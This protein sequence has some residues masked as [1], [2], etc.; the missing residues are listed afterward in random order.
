M[1]M[2]SPETGRLGFCRQNLVV[3]GLIGFG[4]GMRLF[5]YVLNSLGMISLTD[6]ATYAWNV[7]PIPAICLLGGAYLTQRG[8]G[9]GLGLIAYVLSDVMVG[10]ISGQ[11][12]MA[13]YKT[14]PFVYVGLLLHGLM[15]ATISSKAGAWR[16]GATAMA[17]EIVF[18][19]FTNFGEWAIGDMNYTKDLTG[20][21]ICYSAALPFLSRALIGTLFYT[22]VL[23]G[24]YHWVQ[25]HARD[26]L[27]HHNGKLELVR[28][29]KP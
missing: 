22:T 9:F 10:W 28:V 23:F 2:N 14:L 8:L 1:G 16:I 3:L 21:G 19:L 27:G 5:P 6:P 12:S 13:F 25:T 4:I 7:S 11:P 24:I 29:R 26:E 15:G 17:S 18:F 20:L